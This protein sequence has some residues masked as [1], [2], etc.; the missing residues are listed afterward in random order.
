VLVDGVDIGQLDIAEV[1]EI[2]TSD[3]GISSDQVSVGYEVDHQGNIVRVVLYVDDKTIANTIA[4]GI[5]QCE[6]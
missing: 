2:L 5:K 4:E 1:I 3:Y 6:V